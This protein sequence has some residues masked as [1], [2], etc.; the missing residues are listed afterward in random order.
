M[1]KKII[2]NKYSSLIRKEMKTQEKEKKEKKKKNSER[3]QISN[4][5]K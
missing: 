3:H 2:T 1:I 5:L 4:S